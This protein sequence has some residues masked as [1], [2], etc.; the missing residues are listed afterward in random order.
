MPA[1]VC[2]SRICQRLRTRQGAK[3]S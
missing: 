1:L 3:P 2:R